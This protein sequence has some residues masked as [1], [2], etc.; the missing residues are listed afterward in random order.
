VLY[1]SLQ[2]AETVSQY[3]RDAQQSQ[4]E[5]VREYLERVRDQYVELAQEGKQLLADRLVSDED[6]GEDEEED[7]E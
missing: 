3:L 6:L 1:H 5:E 4:D 2:G 7:E